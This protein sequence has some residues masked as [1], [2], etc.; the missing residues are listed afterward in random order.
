[1]KLLR[2]ALAASQLAVGRA[3]PLEKGAAIIPA[4]MRSLPSHGA[5]Q[6][7]MRW[8]WLSSQGV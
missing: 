1:M 4:S 2:I 7:E 6:L 5:I 8:S 3:V